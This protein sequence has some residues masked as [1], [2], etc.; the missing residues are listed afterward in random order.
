LLLGPELWWP[1]MLTLQADGPAFNRKLS[2]EP[3]SCTL[4][5][6]VVKESLYAK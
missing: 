3:I 6:S 2:R 1:T 5:K 4:L